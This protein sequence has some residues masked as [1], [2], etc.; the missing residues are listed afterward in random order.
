M[1]RRIDEIGYA[2]K[3]GLLYGDGSIIRHDLDCSADKFMEID[4]VAEKHDQAGKAEMDALLHV[5]RITA[6]TALDFASMVRRLAKSDE[7]RELIE[8]AMAKK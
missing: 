8:K 3:V 7:V 6:D 4:S 5:L 1:R 2:P